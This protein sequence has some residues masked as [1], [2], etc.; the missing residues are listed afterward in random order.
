MHKIKSSNSHLL[1]YEQVWWYLN[2]QGQIPLIL[3]GGI[4]ITRKGKGR[5]SGVPGAAGFLLCTLKTAAQGSVHLLPGPQ[6]EAQVKSSD[7]ACFSQGL[8]T[9]QSSSQLPAEG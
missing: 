9:P 5:P 4:V 7:T 1:F 3:E 8:N 2:A 6:Q